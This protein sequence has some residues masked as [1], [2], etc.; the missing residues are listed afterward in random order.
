MWD[1]SKVLDW[2]CCEYVPG[3]MHSYTILHL[4][5]FPTFLISRRCTTC[6]CVCPV[7]DWR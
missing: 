5:T 4:L 1:S 6:S 2:Q 7:A 3:N